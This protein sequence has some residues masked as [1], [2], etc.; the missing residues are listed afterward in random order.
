MSKFEDYAN[1]TIIA[2]LALFGI[3]GIVAGILTATWH[4]IV[5]GICM[6]ALAY[7]IYNEDYRKEERA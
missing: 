4:N 5:I 6:G 7:A 3:S 1:K 2:L